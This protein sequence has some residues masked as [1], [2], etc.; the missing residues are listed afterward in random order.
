MGIFGYELAGRHFIANIAV[1]TK[2]DSGL[3]IV[4]SN[5]RK[6]RLPPD[7]YVGR[8]EE[9]G[10][11]CQLVRAGDLAT[12]QR[13][14][15]IQMD[16]DDERIQAHED[17]LLLVN[18]NPVNGVVALEIVKDIPKSQGLILPEKAVEN[19]MRYSTSYCGT[20][21]KSSTDELREGNLA[22][23]KK[24][25]ADQWKLGKDKIIFRW[26][27]PVKDKM[28][29]VMGKA[30]ENIFI[31]FGD[32]LLVRRK[33]KKME[34]LSGV[35]MPQTQETSYT[36][37][38]VVAMGDKAREEFRDEIGRESLIIFS[39][40]AGSEIKWNGEKY[41]IIHVEDIIGKIK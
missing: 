11:R 27:D 14:S 6:W 1:D 23:I 29:N 3:E 20:V 32:R 38:Y 39:K 2:T 37:A 17:H 8:V 12:I 7:A 5:P 30:D 33:E 40:Y 9:T 31:P 36:E 4:Q 21:L 13:W 28:S 24:A 35:I 15:Y 25:D 22:W 16:L 19:E 26:D 34:T 41:L 18:G 10:P